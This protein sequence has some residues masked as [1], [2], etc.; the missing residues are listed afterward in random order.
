MRVW[1]GAGTVWGAVRFM[2]A[3]PE[4]RETSLT[5]SS[6]DGL[7]GDS[8]AAYRQTSLV[9]LRNVRA[10]RH[11]LAARMTTKKFGAEPSA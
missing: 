2:K 1:E 6:Y 4:I 5:L 3:V 7:H 8:A 11:L 10:V 9:R